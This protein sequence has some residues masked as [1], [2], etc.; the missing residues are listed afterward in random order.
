MES[1]ADPVRRLHQCKRALSSFTS[2]EVAKEDWAN[3]QAMVST[4][5]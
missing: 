1:L 5:D 3:P 2:A 4:W